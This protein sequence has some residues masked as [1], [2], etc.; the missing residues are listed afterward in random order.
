MRGFIGAIGLA[1]VLVEL[2][3]NAQTRPDFSGTPNP[4]KQLP[5]SR[6]LA[7]V[8]SWGLA[9]LCCTAPRAAG[10]EAIQSA[11]LGR[12]PTSGATG[13]P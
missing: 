10:R 5:E 6:T 1:V 9:V 13:D 3:A 7:R 11:L 8:K 2:H 4:H 12:E